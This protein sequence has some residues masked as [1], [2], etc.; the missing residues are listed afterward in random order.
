MQAECISGLHC[1]QAVWFQLHH[2][3][4]AQEDVRT[5]G[6]AA[7]AERG[8]ADHVAR[9]VYW[10]PL[11]VLLITA[12]TVCLHAQEDVRTAGQAARAERAEADRVARK[13]YWVRS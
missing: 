4:P 7:R 5:A 6:Q 10:G 1:A 12:N 8:E 2:R 3:L 9:M 11:I 13:V